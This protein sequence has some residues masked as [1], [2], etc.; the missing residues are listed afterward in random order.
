MINPKELRMGNMVKCEKGFIMKI[1]ALG[2]KNSFSGY[3]PELKDNGIEE[4]KLAHPIPLTEEWLL[5]MG[6]SDHD[7]KQNYIGVEVKSGQ[8]IIDF[9]TVN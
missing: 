2:G 5:R 7:Y 8:T 1:N 3:F 9:I 4:Y 6:F